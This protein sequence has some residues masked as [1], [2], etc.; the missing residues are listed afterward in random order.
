MYIYLFADPDEDDDGYPRA[1]KCGCENV[2]GK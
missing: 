1:Y 2:N